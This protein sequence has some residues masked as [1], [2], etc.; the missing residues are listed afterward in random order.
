M[1]KNKTNLKKGFL[2]EETG[3]QFPTLKAARNEY[4]GGHHI[5][6]VW[7]RVLPDKSLE[8]IHRYLVF[9]YGDMVCTIAGA[10]Y[11][12]EKIYRQKMN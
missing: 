10:D 11:E 6:R 8:E 1:A 7:W 4:N 9:A 12:I 3:K 5:Y 2:N